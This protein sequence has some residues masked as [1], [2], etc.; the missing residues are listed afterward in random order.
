M[1]LQA[2]WQGLLPCHSELSQQNMCSLHKSKER[3]SLP[4]VSLL[5]TIQPVRLSIAQAGG[6][7]GVNSIK[8]VDFLPQ[9]VGQTNPLAPTQILGS[10]DEKKQFLRKANF[11]GTKAWIPN[12]MIWTSFSKHCAPS[13]S[14]KTNTLL[15]IIATKMISEI[16][17]QNLKG[18]SPQ[19]REY[20]F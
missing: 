11:P 8:L 17:S 19:S 13:M 18:Y 3:V 5:K 7:R 1:V 10:K 4:L 14:F 16:H 20:I 15:L 12:I 2:S 9:G 6:L